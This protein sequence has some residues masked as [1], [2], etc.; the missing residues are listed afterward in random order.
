MITFAD[1]CRLIGDS[2]KRSGFQGRGSVW[3]L[4]GSDVQWI[5]Q[6]ERP[7]FGSW[8]AVDIGL[9][10]QTDTTPHRPTDCVVL[11]HL[12]NLGL[13]D[14]LSLRMAL[15]LDSRMNDDDR[16]RVLDE[17]AAALSAYLHHHRSFARVVAAYRDGHFRAGAIHQ[18][19][20]ALLDH[21]TV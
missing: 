1:A 15:E 8:V 4:K 18:D 17:A 5:V 14:D 3:R 19:A 10:L 7:R 11:L 12:E 21:G 20:R 9:D 6:V 2:L 16:L 13:M